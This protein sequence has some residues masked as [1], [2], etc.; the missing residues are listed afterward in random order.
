MGTPCTIRGKSHGPP[1]SLIEHP[2]YNKSPYLGHNPK[3]DGTG[4]PL[5][6]PLWELVFG[7][8]HLNIIQC[9]WTK[10]KWNVSAPT[11]RSTTGTET[12]TVNNIITKPTLPTTMV[13]HPW[14][15]ANEGMIKPIVVSANVTTL[16][17]LYPP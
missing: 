6:V 4:Y 7:G 13:V 8:V 12:L 15:V 9:H 14:F 2:D 10:P 11:S 1:C 5:D 16:K 17:Y 3:W